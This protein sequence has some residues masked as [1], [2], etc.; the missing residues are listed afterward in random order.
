MRAEEGALSDLHLSPFFTGR[1]RSRSAAEASGEG[2]GTLEPQSNSVR[3][4]ITS[5]SSILKE[6]ALVSRRALP[7]TRHFV[8]TSPR[9]AGSGKGDHTSKNTVSSL[10]CRRRSSV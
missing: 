1:G 10:P 2:Q 5:T 6:L 3:L 9:I 8:P 7:L 4:R